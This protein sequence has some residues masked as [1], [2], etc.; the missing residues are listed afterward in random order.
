[1]KRIALW[2]LVAFAVWWVVEDPASA[3]GLVHA[4]GHTLSHAASSLSSF[5]SDTS[6]GK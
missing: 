1:M 3:A 2:A 4:I 5:A 6:A